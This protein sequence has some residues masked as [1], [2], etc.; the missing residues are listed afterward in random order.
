MKTKI[1]VTTAAQQFDLSVGTIATA[2]K[3]GRISDPG[4]GWCYKEDVAGIAR[5]K[6]LRGLA[7]QANV[8]AEAQRAKD[9]EASMAY[10]E[11]AALY[12]VTVQR[13]VG[14]KHS[15]K[16][17]GPWNR[18]WKGQTNPED[19]PKSGSFGERTLGGGAAYRADTRSPMI[20]PNDA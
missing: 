4:H 2:K 20:D 19:R 17:K 8:N 3:R 18:V 16:L 15:G 14:W 13:I 7:R 6:K 12:G 9:T 5:A 1:R 10:E 11:A